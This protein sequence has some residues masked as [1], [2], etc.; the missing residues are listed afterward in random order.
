MQ[1]VELIRQYPLLVMAGLDPAT[2]CDRVCGRKG[3]SSRADA[4][5]LDGRLKAGHDEVWIWSDRLHQ[6]V[7][8]AAQGQLD[9]A[10][11]GQVAKRHHRLDV[12]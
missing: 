11:S 2:Q 7:F 5:L 8:L 12:G 1:R 4:R 3:V 9:H 10:L 6:H